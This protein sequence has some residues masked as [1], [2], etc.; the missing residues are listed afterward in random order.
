MHVSVT[1]KINKIQSAK[2]AALI[3]KKKINQY[4][5]PDRVFSIDNL[6]RFYMIFFI[7]WIYSNKYD[8]ISKY[9]ITLILLGEIVQ[10]LY[11][12]LYAKD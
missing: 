7:F 12:G 4:N 11:F 8:N 9:N 6:N 1:L 2:K 3:L 10:D 5:I